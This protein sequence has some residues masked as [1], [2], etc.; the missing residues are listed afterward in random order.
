MEKG[1]LIIDGVD[2]S[3]SVGSAASVPYSNTN[4][5]LEATNTQGAIDESATSVSK[6]NSNLI[7]EKMSITS[8]TS[9][10]YNITDKI[11]SGYR[12]LSIDIENDYDKVFFG[13]D[14]GVLV[15]TASYTKKS[16]T[17]VTAIVT[18]CKN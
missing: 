16:N 15:G 13:S 10:Y 4:S 5:G 17:T 11:P 1:R 12:V 7:T 3:G 9:G 8:D 18:Y 14:K 2:V 6:L